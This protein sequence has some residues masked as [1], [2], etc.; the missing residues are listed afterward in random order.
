MKDAVVINWKTTVIGLIAAALIAWQQAPQGL[1]VK[2]TLLVIAI[3]LLGIMSKDAEGL[4]LGV[5]DNLVLK[6]VESTGNKYLQTALKAEEDSVS[7]G[8]AVK[9]SLIVVLCVACLLAAL[10]GPAFAQTSTTTTT[11]TVAASDPILNLPSN[12]YAAGLSGNPGA[13]PAIAGTGMYARLVSPGSSTYAF[14]VMDI[15]P[16]STAPF[17]VSTNIG[18]G[19]AQRI[20][21]VTI[22]GRVITLYVPTSAGLTVGNA[23]GWNWS[24]GGLLDVPLKN[25]WRLIP[26]VRFV[27]SNVANSGYQLIGGVMFGWGQ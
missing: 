7:K 12:I 20:T 1:T 22:A 10:S 5:I 15:L 14:T 2:G 16:Q 25:G 18:I 8:Q 6:H 19:V 24:G 23:T 9:N 26:N 17:T 21:S 3:A 27:K 13:S 4:K 11:A